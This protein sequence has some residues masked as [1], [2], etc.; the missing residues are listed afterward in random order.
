MADVILAVAT[1]VL[2]FSLV[3][4]GISY[5]SDCA[6]VKTIGI[7]EHRPFTQLCVYVCVCVCVY[8]RCVSGTLWKTDISPWERT[9]WSHWTCLSD[10]WMRKTSWWFVLWVQSP[11]L[12]HLL[13]P[14]SGAGLNWW[15]HWVMLTDDGLILVFDFETLRIKHH[16]ALSS[17]DSRIRHWWGDSYWI[18]VGFHCSAR[19]N[20]V[21]NFVEEG[22]E[23]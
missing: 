16:M 10:L 7:D 17:A 3:V 14:A 4:F 13:L 23:G 15:S 9:W 21:P 19:E 5:V 18:S 12:H 8:H 22:G 1:V 6:R 20:I 2:F 11:L